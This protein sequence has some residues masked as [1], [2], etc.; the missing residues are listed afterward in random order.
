MAFDE[1]RLAFIGASHI[2][3]IILDGSSSDAFGIDLH[4]WNWF[5]IKSVFTVNQKLP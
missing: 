3:N 4:R 5:G 2:I 1:R